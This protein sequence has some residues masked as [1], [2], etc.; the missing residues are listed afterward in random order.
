MFLYDDSNP[1]KDIETDCTDVSQ[2]KYINIVISIKM[3]SHV[4]ETIHP[5]PGSN[6]LKILVQSVII[7]S[8]AHE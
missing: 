7:R 8:Y 1:Q 5:F 4:Y 6:Q 2:T 3:V